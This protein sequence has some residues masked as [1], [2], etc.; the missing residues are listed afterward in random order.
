HADQ[1]ELRIHTFQLDPTSTN[2]VRPTAEYLADKYNVSIEQ[3]RAMDQNAADQAKSDG[4]KYVLDRP[5]SST[6]DMLR[7]VHLGKQ[8]GAGW[9]YMWAMQAELF[10]GNPDAFE[11]DTLIRL[12]EEL[13]IPTD[14]IKDVL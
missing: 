10:G 9:E 11:H 3:A 7:L 4:L 13:G 6:F 14:E 5:F 2:E 1:I 12:G 8:H